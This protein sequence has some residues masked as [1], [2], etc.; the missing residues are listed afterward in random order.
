MIKSYK[1]DNVKLYEVQVNRR[2]PDGTL[3][4]RRR[5]GITSEY[6]A[7]EVEIELKLELKSLATG[8]PTW[9]W[10][11]W[12]KEFLRR[13]RMSFKNSTVINYDVFV[14]K[15]IPETWNK[16]L[17]DQITT[18]EVYELIQASSVRLGSISQ[19]NLLKMLRKIFQMAIDEG[20]I[21]RN[22]TS[23]INIKVPQAMQKVLGARE[24]EILLQVARN[25][26]HRFYHVWAFALKTGMR[27]GEMF[28]LR[29]VDI[30]LDANLIS[31]SRQWTSRDGFHELKTGDWRVVPISSDLKGLLLE[32]RAMQKGATEFVL[33][34]LSEWARGEQAKVLRQFCKA[35]GITEIK[36]HDLRA[37]FITNM[38]AQGVPLVKVMAIV[39]HK[40]METTDVYLRLA[41]VDIKG[42]TEALGYQVPQE[43]DSSNVISLDFKRNFK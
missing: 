35:S 30:D 17:I 8:K 32:L 13:Y 24:V 42:A 10:T 34:R 2:L 38:L 40:Q 20:I 29:W 5:R 41:G 6:K 21:G 4:N 31:V 12:H 27:S 16:K 3:A 23:G 18:D 9:T 15:W 37:T 11:N 1:K 36:F 14:K 39:G 25:T 43:A 7:M 22:P 19:K 26:Q 33:P 28:G